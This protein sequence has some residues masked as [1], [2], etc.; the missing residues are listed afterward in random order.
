MAAL[1]TKIALINLLSGLDL[2]DKNM[3]G[4]LSQ[5]NIPNQT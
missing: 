1:A 2:I 5:N 4:K 3:K